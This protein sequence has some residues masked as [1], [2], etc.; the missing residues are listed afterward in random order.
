MFA[1]LLA[2]LSHFTLNFGIGGALI[3]P[4]FLI[5]GVVFSVFLFWRASRHEL[6]DSSEAFDLMVV[7]FFGAL[8]FG[9]IFDFVFKNSEH[10]WTFSRFLF[11]NRWGGFDFFG[12]LVGAFVAIFLFQNGK[13]L[14]PLLVLDL[15]VAPLAFGQALIYLGRYF[16][17][18][19]LLALYY[20]I[21]YF[22]IF[23]SLK[24]FATKKKHFG[25]F[26]CFY[27][28]TGSILELLLFRFKTD[29]HYVF[30]ASYEIVAPAIFLVVGG[31][32]WYIFAKRKLVVDI[33][34]MLGSLL[35]S[36]FRTKRMLVSANEAG[37]FSKSIILA[38]LYLLRI[39]FSI[40]VT[41]GREIKAAFL[42][43]LYVFGLRRFSK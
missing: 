29:S 39:I 15:F 43:L 7:S 24:R 8:V 6:I 10:I 12:L 35:L 21:G 11:F 22:L 17:A 36:V 28:T 16:S 42:E 33:K 34:N 14:K 41:I 23:T 13:R 9:R 38:P 5:L 26:F 3:F 1:N 40:F 32:I 25:F 31:V 20:F 27:L 30:G 4:T 37:T 19:E 18:K 2:R